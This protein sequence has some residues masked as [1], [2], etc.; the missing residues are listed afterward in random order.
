MSTRSLTGYNN[1]GPC[2]QDGE[3]ARCPEVFTYDAGAQRIFCASCNP[4]GEPPGAERRDP[5]AV[6]GG[7]LPSPL[8]QGTYQ[9]RWMSGDGNRV[10]FDSSEPLVPQDTNGVQDVYEWERAGTGSC[11]Q[12]SNCIYLISSNLSSED[13]F[14]LDA[15]ASGNDVFFTT[16]AQLVPADRN[17]NVDLY[18]AR[19]GGGFPPAAGGCSGAGCNGAPPMPPTLPLPATAT[20]EGTGNL[21]TVA[22]ANPLTRAQR[23][24]NALRQC[25]K[26][27][28]RRRRVTCEAHA[29]RQY[30]DK[31]RVARRAHRRGSEPR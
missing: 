11:G 13:A 6:G 23:L 30:G 15:S 14:L 12:E 4:S 17:E 10:F 1:S 21:P 19:V 29:R 22:P 31:S 5:E 20:F 28:T 16:R 26:Q 8:S 24:K 3:A 7:F 27:P 9:L 2:V 18:D 25:R